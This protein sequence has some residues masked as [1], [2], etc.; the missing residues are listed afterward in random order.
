MRLSTGLPRACSGLS[1]S[2]DGTLAYV[3]TPAAGGP[4]L[5][6]MVWVDRKGREEPLGAPPGPYIFPRLSPDGKRVAV[7][8]TVD[9]FVWDLVRGQTLVGARGVPHPYGRLPRVPH[10][11]VWT[12]GYRRRLPSLVINAE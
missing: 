7:G 11:I 8:N 1:V 4:R 6:A 3:D 5:L 12:Y 9:I 10:H 2:A